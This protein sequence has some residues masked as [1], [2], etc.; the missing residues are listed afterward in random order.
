MSEV[1]Q[2]PIQVLQKATVYY[3]EDDERVRAEGTV[4]IYDHWVR[5]PDVV[6]TWVPRQEVKQIHAQ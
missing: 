5:L 3:V 1:H 6:P 4:E 2:T